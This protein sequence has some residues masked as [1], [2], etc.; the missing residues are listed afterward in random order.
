[1]RF[2]ASHVGKNCRKE[3]KDG[4]EQ[5]IQQHLALRIIMLTL[6]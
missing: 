3:T 1:M 5:F 2:G 6:K 4:E